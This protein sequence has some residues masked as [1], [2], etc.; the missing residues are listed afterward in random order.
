[1]V[2]ANLNQF[3]AFFN[4]NDNKGFFSNFREKIRGI[5]IC[6]LG[7]SFVSWH[8]VLIPCHRCQCS[9][10]PSSLTS[11]RNCSTPNRR[12]QT[13][14]DVSYIRWRRGWYDVSHPFERRKRGSSCSRL[15]SGSSPMDCPSRGINWL[16]SECTKK[17]I[18]K[19]SS[20]IRTRS[21]RGWLGRWSWMIMT[22]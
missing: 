3:F 21:R 20:M 10:R 16:N 22:W 5:L 18:Q 13:S 1:M 6:Q 15:W 2:W 11:S 14:I 12:T 19:T 9:T 7:G 4:Q 17:T 8:G